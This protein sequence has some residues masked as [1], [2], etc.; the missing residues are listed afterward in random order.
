MKCRAVYPFANEV[1]GTVRKYEPYGIMSSPSLSLWRLWE[2]SWV[3][4][5]KS[6]I[7]GQQEQSHPYGMDLRFLTPSQPQARCS[8][9]GKDPSLSLIFFCCGPNTPRSL[10]LSLL[11][12]HTFSAGGLP[13][14][15][16]CP[17]LSCPQFGSHETFRTLFGLCM[18]LKCYYISFYFSYAIGRGIEDGSVTGIILWVFVT[19]LPLLICLLPLS[20][21][22]IPL[23]AL[24]STIKS[25][26]MLDILAD[27]KHRQEEAEEMR[28]RVLVL[29]HDALQSKMDQALTEA[30]DNN[31][32][33]MHLLRMRLQSESI[34][35][36]TAA[37]EH[38]FA[39]WDTNKDN[40][41][42]RKELEKGLKGI[43]LIL[44]ERMLRELLRL[45]DPDHSKSIDLEEFKLFLSDIKNLEE[46]GD[47]EGIRR[48][49][50]RR[51]TQRDVMMRSQSMAA[52]NLFVDSVTTSRTPDVQ[53][54]A[55]GGSKG[56]PGPAAVQ[57][58][59]SAV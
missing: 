49:L 29:L 8:P 4:G 56:Q 31:D 24:L 22:T 46:I 47:K 45:A 16:P 2:A 20:K 43:N 39:E 27:I 54:P 51:A 28:Q 59:S 36:R 14:C 50:E 15:H 3:S 33:G 25:D 42:S 57:G 53:D 7:T 21:R 26:L 11:A 19:P 52:E 48:T 30:G 9:L 40:V 5:W 32:Q 37:V 23:Y 55:P 10:V 1:L 13:S 44:G 34:S 6:L 35:P 58:E 17:V 41:I 18:L 38:W 12:L